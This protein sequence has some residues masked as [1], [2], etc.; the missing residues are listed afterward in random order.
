[1][2]RRKADSVGKGGSITGSK[3]PKKVRG[4]R[5]LMPP[6]VSKGIILRTRM[7]RMVAPKRRRKRFRSEGR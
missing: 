1:M 2:A 3:R 6:L 7:M 4:P 5:K